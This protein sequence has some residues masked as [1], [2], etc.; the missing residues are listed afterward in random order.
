MYYIYHW[1][2]K[3]PL[4]NVPEIHYLDGVSCVSPKDL[5]S[6]VEKTSELY[7]IM[8]RRRGPYLEIILDDRGMKFR[9]R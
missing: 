2:P 4:D 5:F 1:I 6:W 3:T 7:D 8:F 9:V